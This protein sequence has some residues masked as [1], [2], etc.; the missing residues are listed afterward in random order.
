MV[1][2]LNRIVQNVIDGLVSSGEEIGLQVAA[3]VDGEL[4]VDAWAG[5]ADES[6]GRPVDGDTVFTS[7]STTKGFAATCL[8]ILADRGRVQYDAPVARYWPDFAAHGKEGITLRHVL[9]H[10]A[11]LPH[12]PE[13]VTPEMM[14]DWGAMCAAIA[15][16]TP[17]WTPGT[18][19][20][21]HAWTFGWLVGEIVRRADGRSI[22]RFA[23]EELCDPLD[24][25]DFYL[26][27]TDTV[28]RRVAPLRREP[29]APGAVQPNEL[30]LRAM[31]PQVTSAEVVNRPDI[32]RACIPG[33]GGIMSARAIARHYA[34]LAG[35]GELEGV[36]ILSPERID[37]MR[38]LQT[39]AEDQ[40]L[41]RRVRKGLGYFLGGDPEM[42][43]VLAMGR[44]GGEFGHPGLGGSL[45]YAD[46]ARKLALGLTKNYLRTTV[47]PDHAAAYLVAEAIRQHLDEGR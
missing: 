22:A 20:G 33:G 44:S 4:V 3:Y 18:Q 37:T 17:L 7:W 34:M 1:G 25:P 19:T 28:G 11:G 40:V 6:T 46:P 30:N 13:G 43:G 39:D 29:P 9:T 8:H 31:P 24:I 27:I 5:V 45:G 26:G 23:R 32:R 41:G 10:T 36:R 38:A 2:E 15:N 21:Y 47:E 14:C 35:Y 16:H 12:M 42:G